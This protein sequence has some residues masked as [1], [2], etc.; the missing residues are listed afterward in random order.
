M[1]SGI[2]GVQKGRKRK[3]PGGEPQASSEADAQEEDEAAEGNEVGEPPKPKGADGEVG[4]GGCPDAKKPKG[5]DGEAGEGGGSAA[6]GRM[7]PQDLG[8]PAEA[9]PQ[10]MRAGLYN[11]T[12]KGVAAADSDEVRSVIEVQM[13][14]KKFYIR[15]SSQELCA[16][17]SVAW[18]KFASIDAAWDEVKRLVGGWIPMHCV[19]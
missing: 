4:E 9:W 3:E 8:V 13:K 6:S 15:Y 18:R 16:S 1:R 10:T 14:Q 7:S 17:R 12:I 11:Y 2:E 5:A 19:E